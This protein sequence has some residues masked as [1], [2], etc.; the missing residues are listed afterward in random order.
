[1]KMLMSFSD[2]PLANLITLLTNPPMNA[3]FFEGTISTPIKHILIYIFTNR[4]YNTFPKS[5]LYMN[6]A[7]SYK[8]LG[9]K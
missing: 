6:H 2:N 1:M 8:Q 3:S 7:Q 4:I 5:P 9:P